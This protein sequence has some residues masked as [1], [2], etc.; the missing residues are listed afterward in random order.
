MISRG[1]WPWTS[2]GE[3]ERARALT[4]APVRGPCT[5]PAKLHA[6]VMMGRMTATATASAAA[7]LQIA[8]FAELRRSRSKDG[9]LGIERA[10]DVPFV[11]QLA[12]KEKQSQQ[13]Y[14]PVIGVH[15]WFARRPGSL[16]RALLLAEFGDVPLAESYYQAHDFDGLHVADPFMGGG[17]PLLEA[18][19]LGCDV[20]G[21]DI[22]PMAY[23]IVGQ[24]IRHLDLAEYRHAAA[25]IKAYLQRAVGCLYI[26]RCEHCRSQEALV[27][28]F[29]WVKTRTCS[30]CR[31]SIDLFPGYLLATVGRH[32]KDVL[33]CAFCGQL[34]EVEDRHRPG[35][36]RDC[37]KK[38]VLEG[39]ARRGRYNCHVCGE[40]STY[41]NSED[42]PPDHRMFAIEYHCWHCKGGHRGRFFKRPERED[43]LLYAKARK[44]WKH[45]RPR[46][47][48]KDEIPH[49]DET[50]RLHR[51]GYR[52]YRQMFNKRQL[53]GLE[54]LG[55]QVARRHDPRVR[56]ALATN[57]S[58]LLRYQNML[59]RYDTSAL[60]S[61]DIFSIHGFPVGLVQA[62]SNLL[63]ISNPVTGASVGSGGW[64]NIVEKFARA[65]AYCDAPFEIDARKGRRVVV[66]VPNEWIGEERHGDGMME[67]RQVNLRCDSATQALLKAESLDAVLTDPPYFAN[68]QYAELM[69]FCYV[70][71]KQLVDGDDPTFVS[72]STRNPD[73]LTGNVTMD[74]G[75]EHF[76][77][78]LSAVFGRMGEAL[79]PRAPLAFTYHHNKLEAYFPVAVAMLDTGLVCSASLPCPAEMEGSIHIHNKASSIVDTVFVCRGTGSVQRRWLV[80]TPE[81]IAGL[82]N[83]ELEFL[84]LGGVRVTLADARCM[85][86]GHMIRLAV[87]RLWKRWDC[88]AGW[89][90]KLEMIE[91][92]TAKLGGFASVETELRVRSTRA[93]RREP[94]GRRSKVV[95]TAD[96]EEVHFSSDGR[97]DLSARK[98]LPGKG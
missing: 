32:P 31:H 96:C 98:R 55:R 69:D 26:T 14:R 30:G 27:K 28:Y 24:E 81:E 29:L 50:D 72:A 68:V 16:F 15:K 46:F 19:R 93:S 76:T 10:F 59:C 88:S 5:R 90:A 21:W 34:N 3:A 56:H 57:L 47:V 54:L 33:V 63:G 94:E 79:K 1:P 6:Y 39:V 75:L 67:S 85:V 73:E 91:R 62:E 35:R 8:P 48:P 4:G 36:C 65:K 11:A 18:N 77:E 60:K 74:R 86:F 17:T 22:N 92:T 71:L 53:L 7:A 44:R 2:G 23:W 89:R 64:S 12:L 97:V 82:V 66:P 40:P 38:L 42:C 95:H 13:N 58:D 80:E 43:L 87:W 45:T 83:E 41:P 51:W 70:W 9:A 37:H 61:L 49:G 20:T 52:R 78:G 84:R 25:E